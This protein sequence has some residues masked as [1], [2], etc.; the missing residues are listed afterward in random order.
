MDQQRFD[1]LTQPLIQ[2]YVFDQPILHPTITSCEYCTKTVKNPGAYSKPH[3]LENPQAKHIKHHCRICKLV[4]F[5]GARIRE[6]H[7]SP[8]R[9]CQ[10]ADNIIEE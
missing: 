8:E 7:I 3:L 5:D 6:Q 1:K 4:V 10:L 9:L 2:R